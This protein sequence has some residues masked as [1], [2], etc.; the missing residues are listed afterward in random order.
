MLVPRGTES[1]IAYSVHDPTISSVPNKAGSF[2][3]FLFISS[4]IAGNE[5]PST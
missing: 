2:F 5:K 1:Q 4:E 3:F